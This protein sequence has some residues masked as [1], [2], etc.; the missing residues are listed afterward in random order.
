M[1]IEDIFDMDQIRGDDD[2]A[3]LC[4]IGTA[5]KAL[6]GVI[7]LSTVADEELEKTASDTVAQLE[8][9]LYKRYGDL[10]RWDRLSEYVLE[11]RR[12]AKTCGST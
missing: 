12:E 7:G 2:V 4:H 9:E 3:M 1:K 10:I 6:Y 8:R 11:K 5:M